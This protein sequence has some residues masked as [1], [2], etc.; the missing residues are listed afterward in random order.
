MDGAS[1]LA[2]AVVVANNEDA[3][4]AV[5]GT[6]VGSRNTVPFSIKP[7]LGQRPEYDIEPPN[8]QI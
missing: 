2:F 6:K 1:W 5:R 7:D 4:P 8:K 3:V